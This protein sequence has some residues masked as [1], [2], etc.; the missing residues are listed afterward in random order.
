MDSSS[1]TSKNQ[2]SDR[3]QKRADKQIYKPKALR[4]KQSQH[5]QS[6]NSSH[7]Q[8]ENVGQLHASS[9][10]NTQIQEKNS[11]A[12]CKSESHNKDNIRQNN[13]KESRAI[14]NNSENKIKDIIDQNNTAAQDN[15]TASLASGKSGKDKFEK[16]R[17]QVNTGNNARYP[18]LSTPKPINNCPAAYCKQSYVSAVNS[19]S[20]NKYITNSAPRNHYDR[21]ENETIPALNNIVLTKEVDATISSSN[22]KTNE[23]HKD[24]SYS[25]KSCTNYREQTLVDKYTDVSSVSR[26]DHIVP[27]MS[28]ASKSCEKSDSN[29]DGRQKTESHKDKRNSLNRNKNSESSLTDA[30]G[31]YNNIQEKISFG[32]GRGRGRKYN[33]EIVTV[34]MAN[35]SVKNSTIEPIIQTTVFSSSRHSSAWSNKR[36]A[37]ESSVFE[38]DERLYN[39]HKDVKPQLVLPS[40]DISASYTNQSTVT[41]KKYHVDSVPDEIASIAYQ[42]FKL[43]EQLGEEITPVVFINGSDDELQDEGKIHQNAPLDWA[44]ESWDKT[45][46]EKQ[47]TSSPKNNSMPQLQYEQHLTQFISKRQSKDSRCSDIVSGISHG[48]LHPAALHSSA[49]GV[50]APPSTVA[51]KRLFNPD[52][53]NNPV[54]VPVSNRDQHY[55]SIAASSTGSPNTYDRFPPAVD[56]NT[57]TLIEGYE[58]LLH[59]IQKGECDIQYYVNSNQIPLEF[60]R[61]M[62]IRTYLQTCY[63]K[64]FTYNIVLCHQKNIEAQMWKTLYYNIIGE[65]YQFS[66]YIT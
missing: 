20:N 29:K 39:P 62:D 34:G 5:S 30:S 35:M 15:Q 65:P 33:D 46:Q 16:A 27:K 54:M 2:S 55:S 21:V 28:V 44:Q 11:Q 17:K 60:P 50:P 43:Q 59:N 25:M 14:D 40:K 12:S 13:F 41:T 38:E 36:Q 31:A 45:E 37:K 1:G 64:L 56:T 8:N 63:T 10:S 57:A 52:D 66:W 47:I 3:R 18:L 51:T 53:P 6:S 48:G 7:K 42:K 23:K 24:L 19:T 32:R 49:A 58:D 4:Q 61:I 9:N 22:Y 26:M